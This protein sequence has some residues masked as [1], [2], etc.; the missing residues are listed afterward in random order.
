MNTSKIDAVMK[1]FKNELAELGVEFDVKPAVKGRI[2]YHDGG[3]N[4]C[5]HSTTTASSPKQG[6]SQTNTSS[7]KCVKPVESFNSVEREFYN[8]ISK[9]KLNG[10]QRTV[11]IHR[12]GT[13]I[14]HGNKQFLILGMS[15]TRS[16]ASVIVKLHGTET[17]YKLPTTLVMS[18]LAN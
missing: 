14:S 3:F 15:S 17:L 6:V 13:L 16:N 7:S 1:D 12:A 2:T 10:F 18:I 11:L 5:I 9:S 8:N 4:V